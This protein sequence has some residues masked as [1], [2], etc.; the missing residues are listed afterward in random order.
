MEGAQE[1][2]PPAPQA[3]ESDLV[4]AVL[5]RLE[6][7]FTRETLI[8]DAF[9]QQHM[10]PQMDISLCVLPGH[11]RIAALGKSVGV[12]CLLEAAGRCGKVILDADKLLVRPNLKPRRNTLILHDL[13]D[14]V[15]EEELRH[16]FEG[17]PEGAGLVSVKPDVNRTAFVAFGTDD[18]AQRAAL[19]LRSQTL[20]GEGVKCSIKSERLQSSFFVPSQPPPVAVSVKDAVYA[21]SGHQAQMMM[22]YPGMWGQPGATMDQMSWAGEDVPAEAW[23][24]GDAPEGWSLDGAMGGKKGKGK[25]KGKEKGKPGPYSWW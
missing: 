5:E 10:S 21:M 9:I 1:Q 13:P 11:P 14:G 4:E 6:E 19:W 12:A 20:R 24:A 23:A 15:S 3:D 17:S 7:L 25:G 22:G 16:L 8:K 2:P 18:D